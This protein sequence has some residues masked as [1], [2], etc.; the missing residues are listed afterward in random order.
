MATTTLGAIKN[1]WETLFDALTPGTKTAV[2]FRRAPRDEDF[3]EWA[4]EYS[5]AASRR[6][7]VLRTGEVTPAP[8]HHPSEH[9]WVEQVMVEIAYHP[10]SFRSTQSLDDT[11]DVIRADALQIADTITNSSN[12]ISGQD[13]IADDDAVIGS[14][15]RDDDN[16]WFQEIL[17]T[18]RY[19]EARC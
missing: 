11:E 17:V 1:N 13:G 7:Q 2:K 3:H 8:W 19:K 18:V 10:Q 14:L 12:L 6:Y 5:T 15:D 16:V 4:L 9:W